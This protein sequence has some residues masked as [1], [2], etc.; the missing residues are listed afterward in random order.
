MSSIG[1]VLRAQ[2]DIE[3]LGEDW[4]PEPL[5]SRAEVLAAVARHFPQ[6]D[7][8]LALRLSVESADRS[9]GPR[10]ITATGIW[11]DREVAVLRALCDALDARFYDSEAGEFIDLDD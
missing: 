9:E 5:G 2:G 11:G 8:T 10:T 4:I 6:D 3:P 7:A 1:I